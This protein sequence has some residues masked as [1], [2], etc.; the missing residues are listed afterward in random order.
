M[1]FGYKQIMALLAIIVFAGCAGSKSPSKDDM[2]GKTLVKVNSAV[3]DSLLAK[4]PTSAQSVFKGLIDSVPGD[5]YYSVVD[6][7]IDSLYN[8]KHGKYERNAGIRYVDSSHFVVG[9]WQV[10]EGEISASKIYQNESL[11]REFQ[12]GKF[13]RIFNADSVL[14]IEGDVHLVNMDRDSITCVKCVS[15]YHPK[16]DEKSYTSL[17]A[18][19]YTGDANDFKFV[20][21]MDVKLDLKV[22]LDSMKQ[23]NDQGVLIKDLLFPKYLRHYYA[24]GNLKHEWVGVIYRNEEGLVTVE[25]GHEKGY[26][27]NGQIMRDFG[28]KNRKKI[29][30]K[31]WDE[32]GNLIGE[33]FFDSLGQTITEKNWND[34][35]V[36]TK[37]VKYPEYYR[38]FYDNG[39]MNMEFTDFY[40]T[41]SSELNVDN[42]FAKAY[43]EN[44]QMKSFAHFKNRKCY[45]LK[46]W[47]ENGELWEE[48]DVF[49]GFHRGYHPN[50]KI[51]RNVEGKFYY[52]Y[53]LGVVLTEGLDREWSYQGILIREYRRDSLG[54]EEIEKIWNE[55]GVLVLDV[56]MPRSSKKYWANGKL[57]MESKGLLYTNGDTILVDSG[58]QKTFYPNGKKESIAIY[59]NKSIVENKEWDEKGKLTLDQRYDDLGR[60]IFNKSWNE[61]GVLDVD[62]DF[63]RHWKTYY[64]NGVLQY[65]FKG[66]LFY[67]SLGKIQLKEGTL[68]T[69]YDDGSW[70]MMVTRKN[71]VLR[72]MK[73]RQLFSSLEE[74]Q[75]RDYD[76]LGIQVSYKLIWNGRLKTEKKGVLYGEENSVDTGYEKGYY[77]NGKLRKHLIYENKKI[78][79]KKEWD[80]QGR[81]V[82]D[83]SVPNYYREYYDDGKLMQEV[84]GTIVEENGAFKVKDGVIKAFDPSGKVH[85]S[86]IYKDFQV[87][88]EKNGDF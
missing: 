83:V 49:K 52:D 43:Y 37:D 46:R 7:R 76:S 45:S 25:D 48:G 33:M 11:I 27:E 87:V 71:N 29:Y 62:I 19:F 35:G 88:S 75:E 38:V 81:L 50:G 36:L 64:D 41:S 84:V 86:A 65:E 5:Y 24:N 55:A 73:S 70:Q 69:F 67:D 14:E 32:K 39:K 42:G 51:L 68:K 60:L 10:Y 2:Q 58:V 63:P 34:N 57:K 28:F 6:D 26:Y 74:V 22:N 80:E 20:I 40:I 13:Y 8:F 18:D 17:K 66:E 72:N 4:M 78:V 9:S 59:K 1:L 15:K 85:Y 30:E 77:N 31:L 82:R 44:G 79:S 21:N 56:E 23:Y 54:K 16:D 47:H 61:K 3:A 12:K 53:K